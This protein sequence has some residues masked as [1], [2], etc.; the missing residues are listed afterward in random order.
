MTSKWRNG[1]FADLP[2]QSAEDSQF[3]SPDELITFARAYFASDFPNSE[4][5]D[6]P[7]KGTMSGL[8]RSG[9]VP[10]EGLRSHMFGCSECFQEHQNALVAYRAETKEAAPAES[11]SWWNSLRSGFLR[12]P[13]PLFAGALSLVLLAFVGTYVWLEYRTA[14]KQ[15]VAKRDSA[16]VVAPLENPSNNNLPSANMG[17][18]PSPM[19]PVERVTPQTFPKHTNQP[20]A[21]VRRPAARPST[22]DE[23]IVMLINL[24]DYDVTRGGGKIT[25]SQFDPRSLPPPEGRATLSFDPRP[26]ARD[27]GPSGKQPDIKFSRTRTRLFLTLPEGSSK[28]FYTVIVVGASGHTWDRSNARSADGKTLTATL[29]MQRLPPQEYTL[30]ISREGEPPI[31][32][33]IVVIAE[34]TV[35]PTNKP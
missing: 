31:D 27:V 26:T 5:V 29:D 23:R 33:P 21:P 11:H 12:K 32:V 2:A 1:D 6:C 20:R 3:S 35:S 22:E 17:A 15:I 8:V 9:K 25:V 24:R 18:A 28:G 19:R 4:R 30:R 16:P 34:K 7:V 14:P 13:I 10:D